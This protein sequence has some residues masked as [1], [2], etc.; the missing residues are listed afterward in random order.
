MHRFTSCAAFIP[1]SLALLAAHAPS[2]ADG[3][4]RAGPAPPPAYVQECGACHVAYPASMLPATSWQRLMANLQR[5]YGAD[6]SLDASTAQSLG[7][8]LT[9]HAATGRRATPPPE[10]RI[11][12]ST[13]FVREH[14]EVAPSTWQRPS[15]K[16]AANCSAC[17]A[18]AEKGSFDEH[19]VRIPR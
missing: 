19:Q 6:A 18:G 12:R 7:V 11:T 9:A 5:H 4:V 8:W 15:V 1:L 17:H 13:W 3:G 10:D 16:S 2:A 14:D